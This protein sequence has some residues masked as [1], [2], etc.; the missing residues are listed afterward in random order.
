MRIRSKAW[1]V[2]AFWLGLALAAYANH[3]SIAEL[4]R[5]PG[6]YDNKEVSISGTVVD[7]YGVMGQGAYQVDDGTGRMWVITSGRGV[8]SRDAQVEVTGRLH[9]TATIRGKAVGTVLHEK[10]R[11]RSD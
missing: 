4:Q 2:A 8:P 6:R 1:G 10:R 3:Q 9:D 11:R 5:D 7:S